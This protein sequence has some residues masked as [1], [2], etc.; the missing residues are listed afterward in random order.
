[1]ETLT[2]QHIIFRDLESLE[3]K[4]IVQLLKQPTCQSPGMA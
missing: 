2:P 4:H 1:M 3:L